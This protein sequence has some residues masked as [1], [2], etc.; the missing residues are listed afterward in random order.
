MQNLLNK[1]NDIKI[2]A[3]LNM[4]FGLLVF[5]VCG[6]VVYSVGKTSHLKEIFMEYRD[7][8][9][10]S[11]LLGHLSEK[12]SDARKGSLAYR[13]DG[14]EKS[15][16]DVVSNIEAI[17]HSREDIQ[18]IVHNPERLEEL[19][20][21]EDKAV[22]YHKIFDQVS[23]KQKYIQAS[24][25]EIYALTTQ[26]RELLEKAGEAAYQSNAVSTAYYTGLIQKDLLLSGYYT[27]AY[28]YENKPEQY[29][30]AMS[31]LNEALENQAKLARETTDP[32]SRAAVRQARG[33]IEQLQQKLT[34]THEALLARNEL[35]N[36]GLDRVGPEMLAGYDKVFTEIRDQQD[37][38]GPQA[39][40][41]M[42]QIRNMAITA[43]V[44]VALLSVIL[45]FLMSKFLSKNFAMIIG[46]MERL[47]KGD[48][49]FE[50]EGAARADEIGMMAKALQVFRENALEVE[51]LEQEQKEAEK[52]AEEER[53][54]AMLEMADSFEASVGGVINTVVSAST[55]LSNT[56]QSMGSSVEETNSIAASVAAAAEQMSANVQTVATAT[57]ELTA[58]GREI[59]QQV[60]KATELAQKSVD[61]AEQASQRVNGL[62]SAAEQISEVLN[63]IQDI[64]EK[65]NLLALNA[66]IEAA[67]AGDA[68]KGFAVVASEVKDLASQ[69]QKATEEIAEN[70]SNLQSETKSASDS[71]QFIAQGIRGVSEAAA[72]ISAA[73]EEQ[74]SA[75]EEIARNVEEA[76]T[77]TQEVSGNM[78]SVSTAAQETG[79]ASNEVLEASND[80][81]KQSE[82]LKSEVSKFLEK[83]RAA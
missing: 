47:S 81:S 37:V 51:R 75:T 9:K 5:M 27:K 44:S 42:A 66:T 26:T 12:L 7:T 79:H 20:A 58:S 54:Q 64:A 59:A 38:I 30:I 41:D 34:A 53:K 80:L 83:V 8:S 69:T 61:D 73:I 31:E 4:A 32:R 63:L 67:R 24:M 6:L 78:S 36:N 82:T 68:G 23:E 28:F 39:L 74:I 77:G 21:L 65:T 50:I 18:K 14:S 2:T 11:L 10:Q 3:K 40:A 49:T 45:A 57:E 71:I 15:Y 56:S 29:E 1:L 35:Y 33:N 16:D 43:G 25:D 60:S 19:L 13:I 46:Q 72:S 17:E 52:R 22:E 55:E 76:A 62:R 70:V 48:K